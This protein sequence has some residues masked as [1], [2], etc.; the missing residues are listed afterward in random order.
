MV[1][2]RQAMG[3]HQAV[4]LCMDHCHDAEL[5]CDD[6]WYKTVVLAGGSAC[7]PGLTGRGVSLYLQL[8]IS[9]DG[10]Q[11]DESFNL[12]HSV[13]FRIADSICYF[14]QKDYKKNCLNFYQLPFPVEFEFCLLLMVQILC[15]LEQNLLAM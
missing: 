7:L 10:N 6:N 9:F 14:F 8:L 3:L 15:G 5:T 2:Y 4:A 1:F 13:L 12:M 11:Y